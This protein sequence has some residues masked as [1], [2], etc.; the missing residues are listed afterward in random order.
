MNLIPG[1]TYGEDSGMGLDKNISLKTLQPV[2][3][4]FTDF[5]DNTIK[6]ENAEPFI[7]AIEGKKIK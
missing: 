4:S 3:I 6:N 7:K 5:E 1:A 2:I